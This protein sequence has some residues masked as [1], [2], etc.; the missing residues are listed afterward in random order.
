MPDEATHYRVLGVDPAA[1]AAEIRHAYLERARSSHPD[2]HRGDE[3]SRRAAESRMREIN[4][5]WQ[6][7]RD[8][9]R[10]S[11][12]DRELLR[13]SGPPPAR[14]HRPSTTVPHG[15]R[16]M[17]V[18]WAGSTTPTTGRSHRPRSRAG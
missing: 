7:L 2:R 11:A 17:P 10:R 12:Y 1:S 13:C 16:S 3:R 4:A 15:G 9:D 6:V 14:C 8:V 18:T 5:A